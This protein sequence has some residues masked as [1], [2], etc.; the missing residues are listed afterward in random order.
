MAKRSV[1]ATTA[2]ESVTLNAKRKPKEA[3]LPDFDALL[4][5]EQMTTLENKLKGFGVN[6]R[7]VLAVLTRSRAQLIEGGGGTPESVAEVLMKMASSV[8]DFQDHLKDLEEM[9]ATAWARLIASVQTMV[10]RE[11]V[12]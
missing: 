11:T 3:A 7:I 6:R 10:D 9:A 8:Q 1:T 4:T 2:Q 12:K 5:K